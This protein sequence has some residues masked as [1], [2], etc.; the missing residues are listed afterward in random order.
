MKKLLLIIFLLPSIIRGANVQIKDLSAAT[1][2]DGT[3]I[4]ELQQP[5][6]GGAGSSKKITINLLLNGLTL[7]A[8]TGTVTITNAKTFAC[9]NTL[10]F[11][12]TDG[13]TVAFG[14][15]LSIA[16]A[17]VLSVSN[18][19]TLT[20]TDSS[21]VAFGA[22]GT[23]AYVANN[24]S[25]FAATTSAQLAGIISNESGTGLLVFNGNPDI[26]GT[27]TNDAAA[28][29]SRGES[30]T[31][32]VATGS[33]VSLTTATPANV[34]S[35]SLTAGDWDVDGNINYNVTTGTVTVWVGGINTTSATLPT[36]GTEV[37]SGVQLTALSEKN[38]MTIPR[39]R[40]SLSGTT[41]VYLS[42]TVTF[43]AGTLSCFGSIYARRIR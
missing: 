39:K 27:A 34:T 38:G 31:T 10:T 19:L 17:K 30:A 33:P 14:G 25:V 23:V 5:A 26:V 1:T 7:S 6:S 40:I 28:T 4:L 8:T 41:T 21:S 37:Y 15:G 18:T 16:A 43:A 11:T 13:I 32:K 35:V 9:S 29:G 12:G 42:T 2:R 22:G 20:G 36:D 24:L 3:E